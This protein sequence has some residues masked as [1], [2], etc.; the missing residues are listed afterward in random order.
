MT[1]TTLSTR[2]RISIPKDICREMKMKP[3][4]KFELLRIGR[5]LRIVPQPDIIDLF[6]LGKSANPRSYRDRRI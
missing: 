2:F 4:Q 3:G 6:G 5:S 1:S